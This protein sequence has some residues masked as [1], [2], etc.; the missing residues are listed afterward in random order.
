MNRQKSIFN[1]NH[2]SKNIDSDELTVIKLLYKIIIQY[3]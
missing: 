2:I 1:F 3:I